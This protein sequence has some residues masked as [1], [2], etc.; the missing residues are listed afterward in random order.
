MT[1]ADPQKDLLHFAERTFYR[2]R[3]GQ[4]NY[5]GKLTRKLAVKLIAEVRRLYELRPVRLLV[6]RDNPTKSQAWAEWDLDADNMPVGIWV[7]FD[8][9]YAGI[10]AFSLLH[11][12]AHV[13][14]AHYFPAD[15]EDHGREF[16]GVASWLYDYFNVIPQDAFQVELRKHGVRRRAPRYCSPEILRKGTRR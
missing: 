2:K 15:T 12:L 3:K 13:V 7:T 10:D 4:T 5:A 16:V 6:E 9:D 14:V 8:T 11:E 1:C